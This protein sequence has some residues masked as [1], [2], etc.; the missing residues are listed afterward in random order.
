VARAW[1]HRV[2]GAV[3]RCGSVVSNATRASL[4]PRSLPRVSG[5]DVPGRRR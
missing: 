5:L 2:R 3:A 4:M 1:S